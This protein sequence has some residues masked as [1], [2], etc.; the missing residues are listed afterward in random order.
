MIAAMRREVAS[1]VALSTAI[2]SNWKLEW[3]DS[4]TQLRPL[5][6]FLELDAA[7]FTDALAL[8]VAATFPLR[9]PLSFAQRMAKADPHDPLLAQILPKMAERLG[10]AANH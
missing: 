7:A 6:E 3:R 4:F 1:K 9:V 5:L 8:D 2:A 10:C